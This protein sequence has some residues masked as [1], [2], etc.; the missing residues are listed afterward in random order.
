L[1]SAWVKKYGIQSPWQHLH[2]DLGAILM[3]QHGTW[4][5]VKNKTFLGTKHIPDNS[6]Q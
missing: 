6:I 5:F 2:V 1:T 3:Q 4:I